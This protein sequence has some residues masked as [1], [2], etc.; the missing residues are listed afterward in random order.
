MWFCSQ[1]SDRV[2][3]VPI[4]FIAL[5]LVY[6]PSPHFLTFQDQISPSS[7]KM[8]L[9]ISLL[10]SILPIILIY[11]I[12][13][14]TTSTKT[15]IPPGPPGLP[16]IGNL[17]QFRSRTNLHVHLWQ[18]SNNYGPLM[19]MKLGPVPVLV[20]S[21]AELA[22]EVLK[23]QDSAFCSRANHLGLRKLSY[24]CAN[25]AFSPYSDYWREV[26]KITSVHLLN[27]KKNQS[28][29]R[30]REDEVSRMIK[31]ISAFAESGKV[32]KFDEMI[33]SVMSILLCRTAFSKRYD[34]EGV[35]IRKFHG[36]LQ[37]S[38]AMMSAFF[39]SDYFP[40]L[41]WIDKVC[42]SIRRLEKVWKK[43]DEFYQELINEHLDPG[44]AKINE[45]QDDILDVLIRLREGSSCSVE[46][47]WNSI[48]ALLMDIF[49]AGIDTTAA[50]IV[51]TMTALMKSPNVMKKLQLE[52]RE[53]LGQKN[54]VDEDELQ[55]LPY[56]K[57]VINES[58]RLYPPAPLL[59]PRET[60]DKGILKGY[61]VE[62]K[63]I[64]Y[65]NAW[66]IARDPENWDNPE[67]FLPERFLNSDID[68]RGHD[69]RVIPFG[70]G[71]RICPGL[72][73]ATTSLELIVANLVYAFDWEFPEGV[74]PED[75]DMDALPGLTMCKKEPL[76]I[77]PKTYVV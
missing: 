76:C 29:R 53:T 34:E 65:V 24:D 62:P 26:K 44:R 50:S 14:R 30:I 15:L 33:T 42:G 47:S 69:F 12:M 2:F 38:Q 16:L 6:H 77:V 27:S 66:A 18:L 75:I 20:V 40:L 10:I 28:F 51:W 41:S 5:S 57:A 11:L 71:R 13:P 31:R 19:H 9:T 61:E 52:I 64:V 32:I 72:F 63:T 70:S 55:K 4:L 17:L 45:D 49:I 54:L 68:V 60:M 67:E 3:F 74:M 8:I 21:S 23:T 35:D 7:S 59:V 1:L 22:K 39:V 73:M 43:L 46:L 48:K 25:I 58:L 37:D 36:L 56:L